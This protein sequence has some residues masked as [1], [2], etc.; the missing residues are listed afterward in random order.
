MFIISRGLSH[1]VGIFLFCALLSACVHPKVT[2]ISAPQEDYDGRIKFRL[3]ATRLV[4]GERTPDPS[5]PKKNFVNIREV[6]K[7][8]TSKASVLQVLR[9]DDGDRNVYA[10]VPQSQWLWTVETKLSVAYFDNTRLLQKLGTRVEDHRIKAIQAIGT[11]AKAVMAGLIVGPHADDEIQ[12]PVAIDADPARNNWEGLPSNPG[13]FYRVSLKNANPEPDAVKRDKY[14]EKYGDGIF[15]LFWSTRTLPISSCREATLE[16][17]R[18]SFIKPPRGNKPAEEYQEDLNAIVQE[19]LGNIIVAQQPLVL[20]NK[21]EW[22]VLIA[23]Y[24]H[25]RTYELPDKGEIS[26]HT[27]C[28]ADIT[29]EKS[30]GTTS[31][32]V[33]AEIVKQAKDIKDS[34]K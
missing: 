24:R 14:F 33:I 20:E 1:P 26:M 23:D 17:S 30:E 13:W 34:Q 7:I 22:P 8:N 21:T 10:I 27:L 32:E 31:L 25:L 29:N 16:I 3:A 19:K 28:G 6:K 12:I 4:I 5:D 18:L 15:S 2:Y 9:E 11:I